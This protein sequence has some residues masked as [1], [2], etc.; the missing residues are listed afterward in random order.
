MLTGA[1][2]EA[3]AGESDFTCVVAAFSTDFDVSAIVLENGLVIDL[4]THF[5]TKTLSDQSLRSPSKK[6]KFMMRDM[7][8]KILKEETSIKDMNNT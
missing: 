4:F 1:P 6:I 2:M 7:I 3:T 5:L 8:K